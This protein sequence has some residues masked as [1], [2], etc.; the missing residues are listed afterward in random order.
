MAR[1]RA[2]GRPSELGMQ[3]RRGD[4]AHPPAH[5]GVG[6][7]HRENHVAELV[8]A[9]IAA[10]YVGQRQV[11]D[12]TCQERVDDHPHLLDVLLRGLVELRPPHR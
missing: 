11:G 8:S 7:R 5:L 9:R 12:E 1:G 10:I 3:E 6:R 2:P 4:Q